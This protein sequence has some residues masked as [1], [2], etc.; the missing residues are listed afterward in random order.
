[1]P[2]ETSCFGKVSESGMDGE[3]GPNMLITTK[4]MR[5]VR[6]FTDFVGRDDEF[7]DVEACS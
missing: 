2:S 4:L 5:F 3:F 7:L 6:D 1:M